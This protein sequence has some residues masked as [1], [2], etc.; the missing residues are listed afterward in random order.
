MKGIVALFVLTAACGGS[1]IDN[2][3]GA[4][5]ST[6]DAI[7][8][9]APSQNDVVGT[10]A[11]PTQPYDGVVGKTCTTDKDC[12]TANGPNLARCSNTVFNGEDFFPTAVCVLPSCKPVTGTSAVHFCDGPD[13]PSSPGIC[14]TSGTSGSVCLPKCTYDKQGGAPKGCVGKDACN[15]YPVT[16]AAGVGYCFGG[17]TQDGDC[18]DGQK[19]QTDRGWCLPGFTPPTKNVGDAC[20][21]SDSDALVCNCLYGT[22]KTGYCSQ[23]CTVGGA[24]CPSGFVCDSLEIRATGFTTPNPGMA[25][26]CTASCAG[27]AAACTTNSTCT[28]VFAAG[29]DCIPP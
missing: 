9:D 7:A 14:V 10:D 13:D 5:G 2:D 4:D 11:S 24:A 6:T 25:G 21:S 1:T 15:S 19:C 29:P 18:Q 16:V 3:A 27:D 22:A 20:T 8:S 23:F 12:A 28:N 26:Y 17:C